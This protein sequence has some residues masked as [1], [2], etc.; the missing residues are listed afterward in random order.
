MKFLA[1]I[2][3]FVAWTCAAHAQTIGEFVALSS[4]PACFSGF[5]QGHQ[6]T[7]RDV[8]K[9]ETVVCADEPVDPKKIQRDIKAFMARHPHVAEYQASSKSFMLLLSN[10]YPCEEKAEAD[11]DGDG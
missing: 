11:K 9:V 5:I 10:V 3:G 4:A 2:A 1:L 8:Y 7:V 6:S